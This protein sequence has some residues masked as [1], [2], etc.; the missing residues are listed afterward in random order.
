MASRSDA[1]D[2]FKPSGTSAQAQ[3]VRSPAAPPRMPLPHDTD[4]VPEGT[5]LTEDPLGLF[6]SEIHKVPS[7]VEKVFPEDLKLHSEVEKVVSESERTIPVGRART[8][9]TLRRRSVVLTIASLVRV[10]AVLMAGA[11]LV[12]RFAAAACDLAA[13]AIRRLRLP[14]WRLPA[15]RPPTLH[16]PA[17]Q[18]STLRL[19]Q[20]HRRDWHLRASYLP[21]FPVSGLHLPAW[22]LPAWRLPVTRLAAWRTRV[23]SVGW[24]AGPLVRRVAARIPISAALTAFACGV[25]VGGTGVWLSG[26]SR[27]AGRAVTASQQAVPE[28]SHSAA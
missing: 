15:W 5:D 11:C 16:L 23:A 20:L 28:G 3:L 8:L 22:R 7:E 17:L 2:F 24:A 12:R 27:N 19:P 9:H 14:R 6:P 25:V 26:A 10:F 18:P 1:C 13:S 21:K 4:F